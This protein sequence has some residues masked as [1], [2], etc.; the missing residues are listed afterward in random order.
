MNERRRE[1][2]PA[3]ASDSEWERVN[4]VIASILQNRDPSWL[5]AT[6]NMQETSASL[7]RDRAAFTTALRDTPFQKRRDD[8]PSLLDRW[9]Q[10]SRRRDWLVRIQSRMRVMESRFGENAGLCGRF[11]RSPDHSD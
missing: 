3:L 11:L 4:Q 6:E 9:M 5:D 8:R 7:K 1:T 10:E 2:K